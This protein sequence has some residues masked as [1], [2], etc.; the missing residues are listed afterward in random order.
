MEVLMDAR[1]SRSD[2]RRES[3]M[4]AVVKGSTGTLR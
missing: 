2:E 4:A 1:R 3:A